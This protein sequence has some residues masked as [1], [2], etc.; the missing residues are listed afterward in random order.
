MNEENKLRELTREEREAL[1]ALEAEYESDDFDEDDYE[2]DDFDEAVEPRFNP[3]KAEKFARLVKL[4][5]KF[6]DAGGTS[7]VR[8]N[9]ACPSASVSFCVG[10]FKPWREE[11]TA[12]F[13]EM[14]SLTDKMLTQICSKEK[15][16]FFLWVDVWEE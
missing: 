7:E 15:F 2:P 5:R 4:A 1:E 3:E 13:S 16:S 9:D 14:L 8:V 6:Y 11:A 12:I 10:G